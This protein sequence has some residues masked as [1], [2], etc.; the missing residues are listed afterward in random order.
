M[1]K[2]V[3]TIRVALA[4]GFS[5]GELAEVFKTRDSGGVPCRSVRALAEK[6]LEAVE[7]R[8]AELRRHRE[9]LASVLLDWDKRLANGAPGARAGLLEALA[10]EQRV[11]APSASRRLEERFGDRKKGKR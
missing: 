2:R 8:L 6:K 10:D 3:R 7:E 4:I 11:S 5:L 1:V 9:L